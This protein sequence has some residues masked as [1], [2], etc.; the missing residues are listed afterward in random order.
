MCIRDLDKLNLFS[1]VDFRLEPNFF[2]PK[3]LRRMLLTPKVVKCD[4]KIILIRSPRLSLS[5]RYTKYVFSMFVFRL[6]LKRQQGR[7]GVEEDVLFAHTN[8][9]RQKNAF[10]K[11]LEKS[12]IIFAFVIC[13]NFLQFHKKG[14]TGIF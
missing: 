5:L 12:W 3:L 14:K 13:Q 9:W 4:L 7:K 11:C 1:W 10:K 2:M 6:E 8:P